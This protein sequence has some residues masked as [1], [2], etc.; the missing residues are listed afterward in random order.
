MAG[1]ATYTAV[2]DAC[3]LYPAP[4]RDLLLSLASAGLFHARWTPDIENE[5]T[6]NLLANPRNRILIRPHCPINT[7][8][9]PHKSWWPADG[10]YLDTPAKV[11][12]V[13]QWPSFRSKMLITLQS[14]AVICPTIF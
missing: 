14:S 11:I 6:R 10:T 4:L 7:R 1:S 5:W 12:G 8:Y 9:T 13:N 2:L 3:V